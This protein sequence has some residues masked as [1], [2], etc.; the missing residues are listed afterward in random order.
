MIR[1]VT[2]TTISGR[3]TT[4]R[5]FFGL[6]ISRD[7]SDESGID[8]AVAA[9]SALEAVFSVQG[10]PIRQTDLAFVGWAGYEKL[11]FRNAKPPPGIYLG[12]K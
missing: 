8:W 6:Q 2:K 12:S 10:L 7:L 11:P 5:N 3:K 9:V 1:R 4:A